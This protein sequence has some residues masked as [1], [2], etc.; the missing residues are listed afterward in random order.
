MSNRKPTLKSENEVDSLR[1]LRNVHA[2][3]N[4]N[5][6]RRSHWLKC[7]KH[8]S[9]SSKP[10][11]MI[12]FWLD[13][14][15]MHILKMLHIFCAIGI[16]FVLTDNDNLQHRFLSTVFIQKTNIEMLEAHELTISVYLNVIQHTS[17]LLLISMYANIC[18]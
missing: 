8:S 2:H 7:P 1:H 14:L 17:W 4:R 13:L 11:E 18:V 12:E 6:I 3:K 5:S 9:E 16:F 10:N 15:L